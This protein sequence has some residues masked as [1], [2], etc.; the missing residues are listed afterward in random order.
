MRRLINNLFGKDQELSDEEKEHLENLVDDSSENSEDNRVSFEDVA[1]YVASLKSI[2]ELNRVRNLLDA[3]ERYIDTDD[4]SG[5]RGEEKSYYEDFEK[6]RKQEKTLENSSSNSGVVGGVEGIDNVSVERSEDGKSKDDKVISNK[7]GGDEFDK[8]RVEDDYKGDN[9]IYD[10]KGREITVEDVGVEE[11]GSKSVN[12]GSSTEGSKDESKGGKDKIEKVDEDSNKFENV[13]EDED[14]V[15]VDEVNKVMA[16]KKDEVSEGAEKDTKWVDIEKTDSSYK[17]EE[18]IGRELY[19]KG[20]RVA[21]EL[22]DIF[23]VENIFVTT[24]NN[25]NLDVLKGKEIFHIGIRNENS[26]GGN[27][28]VA[29]ENSWFVSGVKRLSFLKNFKMIRSE[30]SVKDLVW[31]I[32]S[33]KAIVLSYRSVTLLDEDGSFDFTL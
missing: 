13:E 4:I 20:D 22:R 12:K 32:D 31:E 2:Y 1:E 24:S 11:V 14:R 16:N 9:K 21:D 19:D 29:Q 17:V 3:Q 10:D 18:E 25:S 30:E 28:S 26:Q 7:V 27:F 8:E 15:S 5:D 33:N 6:L 23:G